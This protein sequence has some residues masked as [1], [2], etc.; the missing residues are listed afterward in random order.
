MNV[1]QHND[2]PPTHVG[3]YVGH[4]MGKVTQNNVNNYLYL[5]VYLDAEMTLQP[6][7]SHVKKITLCKIKTFSRIRRYITTKCAVTIYITIMPLFDYAGF[8]L[9]SCNKSDRGDL[10]VIQNNCLRICYD[11]RLRDRM[12]LIN[13]HGQANL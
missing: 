2:I 3:A 5:G 10:Q 8:L 13:M 6:L 1:T 4:Y 12:T 9:I 11:V 7:I